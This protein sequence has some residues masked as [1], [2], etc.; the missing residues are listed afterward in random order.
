M[1]SIITGNHIFA[2]DIGTR[3]VIGVTGYIEGE[4]FVISA[5]EVLEHEGRF[6][7]DGQIHDIPR[8]A[9]VVNKVK[10]A[11]EHKTGLSLEKVAVAAA[12]RALK[13]VQCRAEMEHEPGREVEMTHIRALELA[14]LRQ[15]RLELEGAPGYTGD[16]NY[17]CVGHCVV[18]YLLDEM[19]VSNLL[20][21]RG[22]R[23]AAEIV[24]TFLPASVV[25]SLYAVLQRVGL[26]PVNLTLE[27][28]AAIDVAIPPNYRL[29]NLAM[30]DIGAGTSDI[31]IT[32]DGSITAYGMV[33]FAGDEITEPI[34]H[35][36]LVEFNEAEKIKRA[37]GAAQ[38]EISYTDILGMDN[39]V[40]VDE[41]MQII[42]PVLDKLARAVSEDILNL[43]G[44]MPPKS[45]FC[46]GGGA[47]VPTLTER[48]ARCLQLDTRRV[49]TRDRSFVNNLVS[50]ADDPLA[51][52]EGVTVIGIA[53][54]A[55]ARMGYE[56]MT[57]KING[58]EYKL[59]NTNS[60][61]VARALGLTGFDPRDL[62]GKNGRDLKFV[63]NGREHT[64]FGGVSEPARILVND[65]NANLQT[66]VRDGD[67]IIVVKADTGRDAAARVADF[68]PENAAIKLSINGKQ[69]SWRPRAHLNGREA[70]PSSPLGP[71]DRLDIESPTVEAVAAA[72]GI[73]C[74]GREIRVNGTIVPVDCLLGEGDVV[75]IVA[76]SETKG[77]TRVTVNGREILL[78]GNREFI[79]VDILSYVDMDTTRA[80]G[81]LVMMVNGVPARYTQTLQDGDRIELYW[82]NEQPNTG[83]H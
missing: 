25:N 62:I 15:S 12:G 73:D 13:T 75:E 58:K 71:G 4:Q 26:E 18:K 80:G 64:V 33:P 70:E 37:L 53:T 36:L 72:A 29:L 65:K 27:P 9:G 1:S 76:A 17:Y 19:P 81:Q 40:A 77:G 16:D 6:M 8:V 79:F 51:G 74:T 28:I 48:L 3:T 11:L 39:T 23:L 32:R 10:E 7:Y 38:G 34:M 67:A 45:V 69:F 22:K 41:V 21:H 83:S 47:R 14:A 52:P 63:L 66:T 43:N 57:L 46:V 54:V 24:A 49:V 56:F 5:Q 35:K 60:I 68:V 20:G 50:V 31:A 55:L 2:L 78:P 44:G 30:V 42:D 61:S 59:F 82:R